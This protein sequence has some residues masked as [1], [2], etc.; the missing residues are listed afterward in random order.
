MAKTISNYFLIVKYSSSY[1]AEVAE[2]GKKKPKKEEVVTNKEIV[3]FYNQHHELVGAEVFKGTCPYQ[4]KAVLKMW[5]E[6][7]TYS[8][9]IHLK[10]GWRKEMKELQER[11]KIQ[12]GVD[13]TTYDCRASV[14]SRLAA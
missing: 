6:E 8:N 1:I 2:E 9:T 3:K 4:E 12:P 10:S 11:A 5:G 14:N 13:R 7:Y